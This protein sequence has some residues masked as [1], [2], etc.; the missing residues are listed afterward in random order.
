M[1]DFTPPALPCIPFS[2]VYED[3]IECK[4]K[5]IDLFLKTTS[6]PY[7]TKDISDL[8]HINLSD[9]YYIMEKQSISS[10]NILSFFITVQHSSSYIC[11]LIQ[12]QWKYTN[13]KYYTP[14]IVSDIYEL[15]PDKVSLAFKQSGLTCVE[16]HNLKEIFGYIYVPVMNW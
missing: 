2:Q 7:D 5:E 13:I 11:R 3:N 9:L 14:Q 16:S 1:N 15:N 6:P 10:F 12:R 8:L 4:I